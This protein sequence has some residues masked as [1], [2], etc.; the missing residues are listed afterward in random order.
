VNNQYFVPRHL[1]HGFVVLL[2]VTVFACQPVASCLTYGRAQRIDERLSTPLGSARRIDVYA[3]YE[4]I[5]SIA[6]PTNIHEAAAFLERYRDGEWRPWY[7]ASLFVNGALFLRFFA[8]DRAE[9]GG[10]GMTPLRSSDGRPAQLSEIWVGE[11]RHEVDTTAID[12]LVKQLGLEW[13][14]GAAIVR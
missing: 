2:A 5:A 3:H 4:K 9:I 13:P 7:N 6:D 12:A 1:S 14:P 10:F 11:F 8:D